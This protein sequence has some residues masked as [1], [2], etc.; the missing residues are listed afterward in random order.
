MDRESICDVKTPLAQVGKEELVKDLKNKSDN[1]EEEAVMETR[2]QETVST[3]KHNLQ[4][5]DERNIQRY[6]P[7][8]NMLHEDDFKELMYVGISCLINASSCTL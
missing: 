7:S 3:E 1:H 5:S 6:L 4:D 2:L 8:P